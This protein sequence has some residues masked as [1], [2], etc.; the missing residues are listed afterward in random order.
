MLSIILSLSEVMQLNSANFDSTISGN[1]HVFVKFFAPWCGHCKEL[2]PKWETLSK[3]S[4]IVIAE[5][6]CDNQDN[7]AICG[8]YNITGFPTIKMFSHGEPSEY[9][10]GRD[11][12]SMKAFV[13][14]QTK[15]FLVKIEK[16]ALKSDSKARKLQIFFVL[17]APLEQ[18]GQFKKQLSKFTPF[19]YF[20]AS[21]QTKLVAKRQ[22]YEFS[23][24]NLQNP[25]VLAAFISQHQVPFIQDLTV[26]NVQQIQ[27]EQIGKTIAILINP[28][29]EF[30]KL[31]ELAAVNNP[32]HLKNF[33][34]FAFAQTSPQTAAALLQKDVGNF[35]QVIFYN[36]KNLK[37]IKYL[38]IQ[39]E[40]EKELQLAIDEFDQNK[41]DVIVPK[42][43]E[44]KTTKTEG[45]DF[46]E[47]IDDAFKN[48]LT[49]DELNEAAKK[50]QK[51]KKDEL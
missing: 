32:G 40:S 44:T 36:Q 10:G 35:T 23:L 38:Q 33:K 51:K 30:Q 48:V 11:L 24:S 25:Q 34:K 2:A 1:K 21:E 16:S 50:V 49:K 27:D 7:K 46:K 5:L 14:S 41:M 29:E 47:I 31:I 42:Q 4:Q 43:E 39:V 6:D 13:N 12:S 9:E 17:Y 26:D 20:I 37:K 18:Y 45:K 19:F 8:K 28:T 15:E 3:E 22:D